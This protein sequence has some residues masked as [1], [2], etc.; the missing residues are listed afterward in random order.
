MFRIDTK[1]RIKKDGLYEPSNE[2]PHPNYI[3]K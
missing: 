3:E 2:I 1:M